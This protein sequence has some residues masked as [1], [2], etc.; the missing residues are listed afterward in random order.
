[1]ASAS[2]VEIISHFAGYLQIFEDIARDR[3]QYDETPAPGPSGDYT[4]LR[5]NYH[6]R[7]APEDMDSAGGP[8]P[9]L[10]ADDPMDLI[11]GRPLKLHKGPQDPDFDFFPTPLKPNIV[12]PAA[13]GGG[14]GGG[15]LNIRVTYEDGGA[16][17]QLAVRQY[18]FMHDEDVN[19]P[20][21]FMAAAEPLI[22]S[23]NDDAMAVIGKLV[24]G[25]NAEIPTHWWMTQNDAGLPDFL[26][27]HDAA[28]ADRDG[29]P[30]EHSVPAGYY[31]NGELQEPPTEPRPPIELKELPDTGDGIGQWASMGGNYSIN[32]A[33]L[34]DI[35]EGARTMVVLGDYFKTDAMFQTNTTIDND[36]VSVSGGEGAPSVTSEGNVA[37]NIANFVQNP[38]IYAE[39]PSYWAG[40]NWIVDVVDGDYYSVNAVSQTNYL[41][42]N[43][44]AAQVSSD[45]HYNLV[46][47][48]NQLGNLAQIFDGDIQYDLIV[49][50]GAYHGM[51]VIFQ[52][53][54]LLNNDN[55]V[56]SADG[57]DPSQSVSSGDNS[58]LNEGAIENY[59]GDT[60]D[61]LTPGLQQILDLLASGVTSIDPELGSAIAGNG[62]PLRVLYVK[63]DYYDINAVWQT[64]ITSDINVL[65]QLQNEPSADLM[66][67]EP[68]GGRGIRQS[69]TTGGNEL[70]NDAAIVDVNPDVIYVEG[71]VYTDSILVQANLLPVDQDDAVNGD[72]D[73]L[74]TELIAF[75]DDTQDQTNTSPAVVTNSVQADPMASVL[76]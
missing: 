27:A 47:G 20:A 66:A 4:T 11:R 29:T 69:A 72:T 44:V 7:Y 17:I 40:P 15:E 37:T 8:G 25:A 31:V 16:Q 71:E 41:S 14:G 9:E 12:L 57:A 2:F 42:D 51:N 46:S 49:I 63:G 58:L 70:A 22:M 6:H 48:H 75:V 21:D 45:G 34:V 50:E 56:M 55:I 74:V 19:L 39:L 24:D 65:Y 13:G 28:W 67:L 33:L 53:N 3:T 35:G 10:I 36:E 68:G 5:P 18:N 30:D 73:T 26:K 76:H 64:N 43:D 23:L 1:M 32:A 38:S 60:F 62:G 59:G 54:I 61:V 52:N